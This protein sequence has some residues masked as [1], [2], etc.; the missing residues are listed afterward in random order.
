MAKNTKKHA[1]KDEFIPTPGPYVA[2]GLPYQKDFTQFGVMV[3]ETLNQAYSRGFSVELQTH[4]QGVLLIMRPRPQQ[5]PLQQV[6]KHMFDQ[7]DETPHLSQETCDVMNTLTEDVDLNKPDT[8]S[9][10]VQKK[11][12]DGFFR[13]MPIDFLKKMATELETDLAEHGKRCNDEN[14]T[15]LK[16]TG[17]V[18]EHLKKHLALSVS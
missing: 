10:A 5:H 18:L 3:Q 9:A 12:A 2:V 15:T 11:I 7:V 13:P 16:F 6:F 4:P 17:V 1:K 14:C 8:F